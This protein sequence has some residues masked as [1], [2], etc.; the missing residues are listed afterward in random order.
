[1]YA[2]A[3][4]FSTYQK[5][6]MAYLHLHAIVVSACSLFTYSFKSFIIFD[7]VRKMTLLIVTELIV[8]Y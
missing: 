5:P 2:L 8:K 3:M 7:R 4:H 6:S 1:M